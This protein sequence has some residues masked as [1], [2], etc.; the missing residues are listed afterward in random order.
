MPEEQ[1][2][3]KEEKEAPLDLPEEK[4]SKELQSLIK[5][6]P[7]PQ[8]K[9]VEALLFA[10]KIEQSTSWTG[11]LPPPDKL[12]AYNNALPDGAE[13]IF[14]MAEKQFQHRIEIESK[15]I[16]AEQKQSRDGQIFAFNTS[17]Y[18]LQNCDIPEKLAGYYGDLRVCV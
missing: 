5:E 11:P 10:L 4:I 17:V 1:I 3:L 8:Q 14:K 7:E 13:R 15:V 9:A 16:P 18:L 12:K 2:H 6:L